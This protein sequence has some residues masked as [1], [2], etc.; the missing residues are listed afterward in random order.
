MLSHEAL[1]PIE[2]ILR[3]PPVEFQP[4]GFEP[5]LGLFA[6]PRDVNVWWFPAIAGVEEEA[7]RTALED[8]RAHNQ[9]LAGLEIVGSQDLGTLS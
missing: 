7:V 8:R 6:F 3:E 5:E 1:N 4:H 9:I 2:L